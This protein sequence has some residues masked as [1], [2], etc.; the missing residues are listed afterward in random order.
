[1]NHSLALAMILRCSSLLIALMLTALAGC[2]S[3]LGPRSIEISEA[4]LQQVIARQFPFNNRFL[5]LLDVT[6]TAPRVTLLPDS[7]RIGTELELS[8]T[9]RFIRNPIRGSLALNYGLRFE[10]ADNTIRLAHVRVERFQIDGAPSG[11]SRQ[12]D[13]LGALLAEQLLKDLAIHT[14]KL[15]DVQAVQGRGY[16]PGD[17][18]VTS[19]GLSFTL[20]PLAAR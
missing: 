14:L 20:N 15:E 17:I 6:V 9:D 1:M 2:A 3:I 4:Q 10:P 13:R 18:K 11:W 16:Q 5:E 8:T 12:M 19:R 7:N